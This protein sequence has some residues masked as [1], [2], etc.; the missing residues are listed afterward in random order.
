MSLAEANRT[1]HTFQFNREELIEAPIDVVFESVLAELGPEGQMPNGQ[2]LPMKLEP[3]PG[4]RLFRDLGND[5]GH[6]WA[7]VQVYQPPTLLELS[8]PMFMSYPA[9]NHVQYRLTSEGSATRLKF[10]HQ[11]LGLIPDEHRKGMDSGWDY[12]LKRISQLATQR[13]K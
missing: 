2:P 4:G 7:H 13:T 5:R 9:S 12:K 1:V 3:W 6:F 10:V 11:A 8:G